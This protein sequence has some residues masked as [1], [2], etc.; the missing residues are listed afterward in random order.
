MNKIIFII[1]L[2]FI[3]VSVFAQKSK[4][5][6]IIGNPSKFNRSKELVRVN[7]AE[8]LKAYPAIDTA[9]FE[10]IN[11]TTGGEIQ[12]Q[13]EKLGGKAIKFLLLQVSVKANTKI[14]LQLLKGK[15]NPVSTK[16]FGRYVPERKDDFA[17]EIDKIAFRMYGKALENTNENA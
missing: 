10:V 17:W 3:Y 8:V 1:C 16:T 15:P 13:L 12:Y 5:T 4:R 2:C 11:K 6:I 14:Q 7:W 9:N